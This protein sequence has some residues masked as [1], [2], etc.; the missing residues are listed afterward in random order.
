MIK[1]LFFIIFFINLTIPKA[2]I[3]LRIPGQIRVPLTLGYVVFLLLFL[4]WVI[5]NIKKSRAIFLG[6]FI[7]KVGIFYLFYAFLIYFIHRH[8][9]YS[10]L[11]MVRYV[12]YSGSLAAF[13]LALDMAGRE[14]KLTGLIKI[15]AIS[16]S[17]VSIYGLLQV[18]FD[19][20]QIAL[21]GLT[22]IYGS[23]EEPI[24]TPDDDVFLVQEGSG[25]MKNS[26]F[27]K[28]DSADDSDRRV[29]VGRKVFSTFHH[30]N[31]FGSH[32]VLFSPIIFSLV[33]AVRQRRQK[34]IYFC[35][36]VITFLSLLFANSRGALIGFFVSCLTLFL[37][38]AEKKKTFLSLTLVLLSGIIFFNLILNL[39]QRYN[40]KITS[41]DARLYRRIVVQ[42]RGC[43][44]IFKM[45]RL[46]MEKIRH[47]EMSVDEGEKGTDY[48]LNRLTNYRYRDFKEFC[49]ELFSK[50]NIKFLIFGRGYTGMRVYQ[51]LYFNLLY[52]LGI[53]GL[54]LFLSIVIYILRTGVKAVR[55]D[56]SGGLIAGGISGIAGFLVHNLFDNLFYF[57]PMALNFWILS[58]LVLGIAGYKEKS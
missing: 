47:Q 9:G 44:D 20:E 15:I 56:E 40:F 8:S 29:Y 54:F 43:Q 48:R 3:Y 10:G 27:A 38:S 25:T 17:L 23:P 46:I 7:K 12:I 36:A 50:G 5:S 24:I 42:G 49:R 19:S 13:Y 31:V 55:G 53:V 4:I 30:G 51:N 33:G 21:V 57:P 14:G 35:L 6:S 58:G 34:A 16:M 52:H 41:V 11:I 18:F 22:E 39:A 45:P 26:M 32:L 37:I 1:N 2:G 28:G